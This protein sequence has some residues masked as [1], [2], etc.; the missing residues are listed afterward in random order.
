MAALPYAASVALIRGGAVLLIER[1]R[2]PYAGAFTLPGGRLELGETAQSCALRE[3][4]EELGLVLSD[5][6]PVLTLPV[7]ARRELKL[8][9]FA[10]KNFSGEIVASDEVASWRWVLPQAIGALITTPDL[11]MVLDRALRLF[12]RG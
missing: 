7:G 10:T 3:V 5:L 12:E 2:P 9:V 11:A 8:A 4:R 6:R 1:G